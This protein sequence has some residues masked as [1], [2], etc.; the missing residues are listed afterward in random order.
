V[1]FKVGD[2]V[3][4]LETLPGPFDF[5]LVDLWKD[6]YIPCFDRFVDK[7]TDGALVVADNMLFP[8]MSRAHA[9]AYRA[10]VRESGR[11]DT[12]LLPVG[13]GIEVSRYRG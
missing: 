8:E 5:V 11:F 12:V 9:D 10:R 6:L 3:E 1:D 13:S 4:L 2:A 7:L